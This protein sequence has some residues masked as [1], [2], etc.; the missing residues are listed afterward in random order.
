MQDSTGELRAALDERLR[1]VRDKV[2]FIGDDSLRFSL[3]AAEHRVAEAVVQLIPYDIENRLS[4]GKGV[5]LALQSEDGT[6]YILTAAHTLYR[7][8]SGRLR[9]PDLVVFGTDPNAK[10]LALSGK[11]LERKFGNGLPFVTHIDDIILIPITG[12]PG[13]R[14]LPISALRPLD[15]DAEA[16]TD[17]QST[18]AAVSCDFLS[19]AHPMTCFA[20]SFTQ[21]EARW[22]GLVSAVTSDLDVYPGLSGSPVIT[23]EDAQISVIGVIVSGSTETDC[24]AYAPPECY[25]VVGPVTDDAV[26]SARQRR[27]LMPDSD[28]NTGR[29]ADRSQSGRSSA[30]WRND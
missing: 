20:Q 3:D 17:S 26:R 10:P 11:N 1:D 19:E 22:L 28:V 12:D 25:T 29:D 15:L 24:V 13:V 30:W 2:L 16:L 7:P 8:P 6:T 4:Y 9:A 23:V 27:P 5:G 14:P 21:L 18:L